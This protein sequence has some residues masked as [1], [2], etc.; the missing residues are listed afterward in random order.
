MNVVDALG[1]ALGRRRRRQPTLSRA[2]RRRQRLS[3]FDKEKVSR[4]KEANDN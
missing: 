1:R 4:G 2:S 3:T